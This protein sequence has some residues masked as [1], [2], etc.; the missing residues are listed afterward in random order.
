MANANDYS[1]L[2]ALNQEIHAKV[3]SYGLDPFDI[4]F[5]VLTF[6]EMNEVASYDGFPVRYPHWRFGMDYERLR[7]QHAYGLGKIYEAYKAIQG[8]IL[9]LEQTSEGR[10]ELTIKTS[11]KGTIADRIVWDP[12][13]K[14]FAIA[15]PLLGAKPEDLR[16]LAGRIFLARR[17]GMIPPTGNGSSGAIGAGWKS[18]IS[19]TGLPEPQ[20]GPTACGWG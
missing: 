1:V 11:K 10:F 9:V 8:T 15:A 7:K 20:A 5:E 14:L 16:A 4:A 6:E 12:E 18:G 17:T 13:K 2:R 3:L 19:T